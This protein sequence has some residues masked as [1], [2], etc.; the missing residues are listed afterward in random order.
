MLLIQLKASVILN[1]QRHYSWMLFMFV[2][3]VMSYCLQCFDT[4]GLVAGKASGL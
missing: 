3:I 2:F 4:V 1:K